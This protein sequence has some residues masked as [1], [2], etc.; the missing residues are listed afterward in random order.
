MCI[1]DASC[2][3]T[4]L[5]VHDLLSCCNVFSDSEAVV[6]N[7]KALSVRK[8]QQWY[9]CLDK[10]CYTLEK[11]SGNE[12]TEAIRA[13]SAQM[14]AVDSFIEVL[15]DPSTNASAARMLNDSPSFLE[16]MTPKVGTDAIPEG[17]KEDAES[18]GKPT[19]RH[20]VLTSSVSKKCLAMKG[21]PVTLNLT[22]GVSRKYGSF[23]SA[24]VH[25]EPVARS[26]RRNSRKLTA[27]KPASSCSSL[28]PSSQIIPLDEAACLYLRSRDRNKRSARGRL[29]PISYQPSVSQE[30]VSVPQS[31][32]SGAPTRTVSRLANTL[33]SSMGMFNSNGSLP[34]SLCGPMTP[35][36][37]PHNNVSTARH[38]PASVMT[39]QH[40]NSLSHPSS[41][42][43]HIGQP[44]QRGGSLKL[45]GVPVQMSAMGAGVLKAVNVHRHP[46]DDSILD[47]PVAS[48]CSRNASPPGPNACHT[49]DQ[50]EQLASTLS[51]QNLLHSIPPQK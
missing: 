43:P 28:A 11:S 13:K 33:A 32:T 51:S 35:L 31:P 29:S 16:E 50:Y 18:P 27:M 2:L 17:D 46:I 25:V 1:N 19:R 8:N 44:P 20:P 24:S 21:K 15:D 26:Y 23:N 36:T 42:Q 34:P 30:S 47:L 14:S 9:P 41:T 37:L 3:C 4:D 22:S 39:A 5:T 12:V 6:P 38:P 7:P 49:S 40:S 45:H 48:S 10:V